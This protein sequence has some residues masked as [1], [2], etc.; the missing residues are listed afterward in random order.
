MAALRE[1]VSEAHHAMGSPGY[2]NHDLVQNAIMFATV[3]DW[4]EDNWSEI[5]PERVTS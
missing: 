4:L 2:S 3:A 1:Q 5:F